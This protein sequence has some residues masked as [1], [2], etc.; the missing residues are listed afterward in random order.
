MIR[1]Y[2]WEVS[3]FGATSWQRFTLRKRKKRQH[4]VA[5]MYAAELG[6][7]EPASGITEHIAEKRTYTCTCV[8]VM[9]SLLNLYF[10]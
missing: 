4:M 1:L 6:V 9:F 10:M 8:H 3:I 2:D 5:D 7:T